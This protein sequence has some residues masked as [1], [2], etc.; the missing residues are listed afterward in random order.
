MSPASVVPVPTRSGV[1]SAPLRAALLLVAAALLLQ[2]ANPVAP[3]GGPRDTTPPSVAASRPVSDTVNVSTE[4]QSIRITF[5]EYVERSTL[6][7]AL[8]ITPSPEGRL[9]FDWS[10]RTVNV[11]VPTTLR[12][13]TTYIVSLGTDLTDAH[14]V[15]LEEPITL[16]FSTGPRINQGKLVGRVVT[17]RRGEA[18]GGV[19]VFAYATPDTAG[20]RAPRPL[21]EQPAYRTQT[22]EDGR[23]SFDYLREQRYYVVALRDNNRNRRPDPGEAVAAPPHPALPADSAAAEVPVPWLLTRS[24]T[25]GPSLQQVRALSRQRLRLRFDEPVRRGTREPEAWVLRDSTTGARVPVTAVYT[26]PDREEAIV[27]RTDPMETGRHWVSIETE[28]VTDTLGQ[29]PRPDTARFG[30]VPQEDTVQ[31]RFR[32]FVPAEAPP[33]TAD[34]YPLLPEEAPGVRFNQAPDSSTLRERLSVRD[35]VET[36]RSYTLS[37]DDGRT[38][39][40]QTD[41]PLE[42]GEVLEVAVAAGPAGP[43]TTYQRRFYRVSS[44]RLG[45]LE[46]RVLRTDTTLRVTGL[47]RSA[48]RTARDTAESPADSSSEILVELRPGETALPVEPRRQ[49]VAAGSTFV[50]RRLPEG[51]YRFRAVLDRNGN[52]RWDGGQ[53]QPYVP[54]EPLTWNGETTEA[55]P[56]WTTVL[57]APLRVPL[58]RLAPPD[59]TAASSNAEAPADSTAPPD[60]TSTGGP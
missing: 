19:D 55:R 42:P 26:A 36:A 20:P 56:R 13:S 52:G 51:D 18:Q 3:S 23:F 10:G 43:D 29:E 49:T 35:T 4:T 6:P 9:Q 16:A 38:H 33:D 40:V 22:G 8:S 47:E 17:P 41:P 5:S 31:T 39:R 27:L 21:P 34:L 60:T 54:P 28:L 46:G 30:A 53:I 44:R 11:E 37:S 58:L 57:P 14:G 15:S 25:T 50:F 45:A 12:D 32:T 7:G 24:D 1:L 48:D 59:T 2:C